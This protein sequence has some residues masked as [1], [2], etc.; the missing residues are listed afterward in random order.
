MSPAAMWTAVEDSRAQAAVARVLDP[1]PAL[2]RPEADE[3]VDPVPVEVAVAIIVAGEASLTQAP[4]SE[5]R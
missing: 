1:D 2:A 4:V 5:F 3:V